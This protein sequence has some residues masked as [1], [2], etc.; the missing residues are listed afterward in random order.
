MEFSK[1]LLFQECSYRNCLGIP[2]IKYYWTGKLKKI[3]IFYEKFSGFSE[4]IGNPENSVIP[5]GNTEFPK[6]LFPDFLGI[7]NFRKCSSP[8]LQDSRSKK[9]GRNPKCDRDWIQRE[10]G[11]EKSKEKREIKG[12]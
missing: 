4:F 1:S 3:R 11:K 5:N 6:I 8:E 2:K 9:F 10:K 7:P 12:K